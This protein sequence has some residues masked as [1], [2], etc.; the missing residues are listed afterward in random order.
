MVSFLF[1]VLLMHPILF[2]SQDPHFSASVP[3][4][5]PR[6]SIFPSHDLIWFEITHEFSHGRENLAHVDAC[7]SLYIEEAGSYNFGRSSCWLFLIKRWIIFLLSEDFTYFAAAGILV[8]NTVPVDKSTTKS[9]ARFPDFWQS[10]VFP[11]G[12]CTS[13]WS[14]VSWH[15]TCDFTVKAF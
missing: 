15:S 10:C 7:Q 1:Y 9:K 6:K 13:T 2:V 3:S 8:A 14:D 11:W 12:K 4:A 5:H